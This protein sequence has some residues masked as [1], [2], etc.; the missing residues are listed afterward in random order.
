M[1]EVTTEK[2]PR[3]V[4]DLAH[5]KSVYAQSIDSLIA[6]H[7]GPTPAAKTDE[8]RLAAER[9]RAAYCLISNP[10]QAPRQTLKYYAVDLKVW[11]H[12]LGDA[13]EVKD[14]RR[15]SRAEKQQKVLDWAADNV[16]AEVTLEK[17]MEVGDVAYTMAKKI[18]E[19]RPD[20]FWKKKRGLF[21]IRDPKADREAEKAS[22]KP[23][24]KI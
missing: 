6:E 16:G 11:D 3:V 4:V 18:V 20:V 15:M 21:T 17:L 7:G 8:W 5:E 10:D 23:T 9:L 14:E 22:K 12:F 2:Q 24:E 19:N 13:D 1:T